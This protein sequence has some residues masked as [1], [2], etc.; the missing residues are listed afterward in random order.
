MQLAVAE[1]GPQLSF[2]S[3][4]LCLLF[5]SYFGA[6]I[7]GLYF[8]YRSLPCRQLSS[9]SSKVQQW[10]AIEMNAPLPFFFSLV[11][12]KSCFLTLE[13]QS[14]LQFHELQNHKKCGCPPYMQL[15]FFTVT[16]F[17][18]PLASSLLSTQRGTHGGIGG[19]DGHK[20]VCISLLQ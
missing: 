1:L 16:F 13:E 14:A 7:F 6:F 5:L 19:S 11:Q 3:L 4:C 20:L 18:A 9:W 15:P 8:W 2:W 10:R 17:L 12:V